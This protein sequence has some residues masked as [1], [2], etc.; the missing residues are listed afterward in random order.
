MCRSIKTLRQQEGVA[1]EEEIR[2][3]AL[4]FVRKVTGQRVPGAAQEPVFT[5]AVDD[6]AAVSRRLLEALPPRRP[7]RTA[8]PRHP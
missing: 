2:A 4:Q 7:A 6:I 3:A 1:T 8:M 5:A